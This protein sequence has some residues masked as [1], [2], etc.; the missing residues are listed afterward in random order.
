MFFSWLSKLKIKK[1]QNIIGYLGLIFI[2]FVL[3]VWWIV[4][5]E[6]DLL[7]ETLRPSQQLIIYPSN[8]SKRIWNKIFHWSIEV[9]IEKENGELDVEVTRVPNLF[10]KITRLL[11]ILVIT[12]SVTMILYNWIKYIVKVWQWEDSKSLM[13]NVAYIIVW[14]LVSLFS[15]VII[16]L[17]RSVPTTLNEKLW[18]LQT[19]NDNKIDLNEIYDNLD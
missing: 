19:D 3:F 8:N 15:V 12:L 16:T 1:R 5:A 7:Y 13:K 18:G 11:L 6:R 4:A 14:I 10:A 2:S 17:L 9:D